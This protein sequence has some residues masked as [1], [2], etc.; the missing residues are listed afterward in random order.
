[1][2]V[3]ILLNFTGIAQSR[4][5]INEIVEE[6]AEIFMKS[7]A[8]VGTSV[9]ILLNGNIYTYN[10]GS[11]SK[12]VNQLPT[13]H[14]IYGIASLSK[15]FTGLL[16]AIAVQEKKVKL[17]DDIRKYLDGEYKNLEYDLHPIE[18]K[19]LISHVSR[20][21][22][23]LSD[24][25][26]KT[27]YTRS[28]FYKDL[29]QVRVD[30]VPGVKFQYSNAAVQLLGY[31]LEK[32]YQQSFEELLREKI[33]RPLKM[34]ETRIVLNMHDKK[35]AAKGYT[36]TGLFDGN[37]YNYLQAAGGIKSSVA[38]L[39]KYMAY[40]M[41]ES[42]PAVALSHKEIWGFDIGGGN[43]YSC[44][45]NWQVVTLPSGNRRVIQNGSL[46]NCSSFIAFSPTLKAGIVVL[47]NSDNG[48][49]VSQLSDSILKALAPALY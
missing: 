30:T 36:N 15:T 1:M 49:A 10:Y 2:L 31:I 33:T 39:L 41:D 17:D 18:L 48:D 11:V 3:S 42:D 12:D 44:A 13:S 26:E 37:E 46:V 34:P 4:D 8:A 38:D 20:L 47:S 9:G 40:Q 45:L 28:D 7:K 16:L 27:G 14:T 5:S 29:H 43:H 19:H 35:R 32:V 6:S 23:W 25:A 24:R 21:P 22:N